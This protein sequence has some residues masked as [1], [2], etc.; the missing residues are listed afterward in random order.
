MSLFAIITLYYCISKIFNIN[1][2]T[3]KITKHLYL[4]IT[5]QATLTLKVISMRLC[6]FC[7]LFFKVSF[8][9]GLNLCLNMA[10]F[11]NYNNKEEK[12]KEEICKHNS[13][14]N[15]FQCIL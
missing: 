14:S 1:H 10:T 5:P 3:I 8:N 6:F 15:V 13:S 7:L 2:Y 11:D 12:E 9:F 4:L